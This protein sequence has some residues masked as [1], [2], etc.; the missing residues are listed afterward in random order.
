MRRW[1]CCA[2]AP[3][4]AT[5][6]TITSISS[7]TVKD[8]LLY[9][10]IQLIQYEPNYM[11]WTREGHSCNTLLVD[12]QSP[13]PSPIQTRHDFAPSVK[14]FAATGSPFDGR[15]TNTGAGHDRKYLVDVFRAADDHGRRRTFDWL[16]Q[17]WGALYVRSSRG[18]SRDARTGAVLLVG[19]QRAWPHDRPNLAGGLDSAQRRRDS[20]ACRSSARNGSITPPPCRMTMLGQSGDAGL[21]RRWPI[22]DSPPY[23]KID[24]DPEGTVPRCALGAREKGHDIYCN[25]RTLRQDGQSY[26][27]R[28]NRGDR[29]CR[30]ARDGRRRI[31]DRDIGCICRGQPQTLHSAHETFSFQDHASIRTSN[32][33]VV[34]EGK[35]DRVPHSCPGRRQGEKCRS[36]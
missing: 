4:S 29:R 21:L 34:V 33:Q 16:L 6:T 28:P 31:S 14:F 3:P 8:R 9:P 1:R 36:W 30:G 5:A 17:D 7:C 19:R 2:W 15:H 32:G 13:H 35:S 23:A 25:P 24:G 18:V 26:A 27:D 11:N 22:G 10:T 20:R 12:H